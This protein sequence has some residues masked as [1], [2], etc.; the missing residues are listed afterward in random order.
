MNVATL[1][2]LYT[3]CNYCGLRYF[4]TVHLGLI[5]KCRLCSIKLDLDDIQYIIKLQQLNDAIEIVYPR[6]HFEL[7]L[8]AKE[9]NQLHHISQIK[10]SM[11]QETL[12]NHVKARLKYRIRHGE[13]KSKRRNKRLRLV[14]KALSTELPMAII[15]NI[16]NYITWEELAI[17]YRCAIS[18]LL[19]E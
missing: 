6:H 14:A 17:L 3:A 11:S 13:W 16:C 19:V 15:I 7:L 2:K 18:D 5:K 10:Y 1:A 12:W 4:S 9:C 8:S